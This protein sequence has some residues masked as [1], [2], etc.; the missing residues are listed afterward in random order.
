MKVNIFTSILLISGNLNNLIYKYDITA[1]IWT[2]FGGP[3]KKLGNRCGATIIERRS[4]G[5]L[6]LM[7][8]GGNSNVIQ[9]MDLT[10]YHNSGTVSWQSQT[11]SHKS[12]QT[13]LV[14]LSSHEALE[15]N[16]SF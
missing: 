2:S 10:K 14:A 1:N 9:Y 4:N 15:V 3:G 5:Q 16:L 8:V 13:S 12:F 6:T 7:W 11:S